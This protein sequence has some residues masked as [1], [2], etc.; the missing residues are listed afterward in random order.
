VNPPLDRIAAEA[1]A[2]PLAS[3][4]S[5]REPQTQVKPGHL[6]DEL[7]G[8][9]ARKFPGT[10]DLQGLDQLTQRPD[11][12]LSQYL[13]KL[14]DDFLQPGGPVMRLRPDRACP[15]R[16]ILHWRWLS[17]RLPPSLLVAAASPPGSTPPERVVVLDPAL[18]PTG[19]VA[20]LHLHRSGNQGFE[21]VWVGIG[22]REPTR[23]WMFDPPDDPFR[24]SRSDT[25]LPNA[26]F[27]ADRRSEWGCLLRRAHLARLYLG[28]AAC[29]RS[30]VEAVAGRSW[31]LLVP[32]LRGCITPDP[33][34]EAAVDRLLHEAV[35]D[36]ETGGEWFNPTAERRWLRCTM[37]H[38]GSGLEDQKFEALWCQVV[39]LK[40]ICYQWLVQSPLE[41]GLEA[42]IQVLRRAD[43]LDDLESG[44]LSWRSPPLDVR[45]VELRGTPPSPHK[46]ELV[47]KDVEDGPDRPPHACFI[48]HLLRSPR[49]E[50]DRDRPYL[51]QHRTTRDQADHFCRLLEGPGHVL[52][53]IRGLDLASDELRGPLWLHAHTIARVR[54][55]SRE[56][57]ARDPAGRIWPLRLTLHAGEQFHH[58]LG[59]LRAVHEPFIWGLMERGDR[60][61]HASA[62]GLDPTKWYKKHQK[63]EVP[64]LDRLLDLI[65]LRLALEKLNVPATVDQIRRLDEQIDGTARDIF[66]AGALCSDWPQFFEQLGTRSLEPPT[67]SSLIDQLMESPGTIARARTKCAVG[68][69]LPD[70][71]ALVTEVQDALLD[72]LSRWQT[73]IEVCPSSN[74]L[75]APFDAPLDQ[76]MFHLRPVDPDKHGVLPVCISADDPLQFATNLADEYAYAWAGIV[77]GAESAKPAAWARAWLDDA[78]AASW[79]HRFTRDC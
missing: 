55:W 53:W 71:A 19:K 15:G 39:R 47:R 49:G 58:L 37:D 56:L 14:G 25:P 1:L 31:H 48:V 41:S 18:A 70:E 24:V 26:R 44:Q 65:W 33:F 6:A 54:S 8:R 2:W 79:R 57:A 51:V 77:H 61:G 10:P 75:I 7:R 62:L 32:L 13:S 73:A 59:G 30:R 52:S 21:D 72:H 11:C 34:D 68:A 76:P 20:H 40:T 29:E 63:V 4:D 16:E 36:A 9:L 22:L 46:L 67:G 66:F 78:A 69:V 35:L 27:R 64:R 43:A 5:F 17:L 42:F 50:V 28:R 45:A 3:P 12:T 23:R 38:L 60:L 74:L